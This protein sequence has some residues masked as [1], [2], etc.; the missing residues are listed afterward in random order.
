MRKNL[1]WIIGWF[2]LFLI[3]MPVA[4]MAQ[5][6]DEGFKL[7]I[8][9]EFGYGGGSRIQGRFSMRASGPE[10]INR[11]EFLIDG[12]VVFNDNELPFRYDFSTGEYPAGVHSL[13]AI[14]YTNSGETLQSGT[15]TYE[16]VTAEQARTDVLKILAPI[17]GLVLLF[18]I[19][20][21]LVP[22]LMGKRK[23]GFRPG[24]YG[25]AGGAV[26]TRCGLPFTRHFFSP[27][28]LL[29]KLERCPHCGK[30][31]IVR[32]A[33]R[34]ELEAA[35]ARLALDEERGRLT[36]DEDEQERLKRLID[37]SRFDQ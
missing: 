20:G 9:R 31:G 4:G 33:S 1:H 30:W 19:V 28:L 35:E 24:E 17:V 12:E 37:E 29:G 26:C 7:S 5:E 13:S 25:S 34:A 27:N 32:A 14:G 11:V 2:V 18:M 22:F 3:L 15:W 21:V 8:R 6:E 16:F 10:S 36:P 23:G